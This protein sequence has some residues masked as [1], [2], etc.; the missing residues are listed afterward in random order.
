LQTQ[1][2]LKLTDDPSNCQDESLT[3][4]EDVQVVIPC[5][6]IYQ[7][8]NEEKLSARN[9]CKQEMADRVQ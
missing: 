9:K 5:E 7:L 2:S 3:D 4:D 1:S 8:E 6:K